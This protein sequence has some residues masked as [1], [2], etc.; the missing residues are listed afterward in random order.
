MIRALAHAA[1]TV[2]AAT[3]AAAVQG[4][5]ILFD[6]VARVEEARSS[7]QLANLRLDLLAADRGV[8][9]LHC[10]SF[11]VADLGACERLLGR[12]NLPLERQSPAAAD[13]G[14]LIADRGAT[15]GVHLLFCSAPKATPPEAAAARGEASLAVTGLD[16]LV[17]RTPDPER[18]IALYAGR[19]GLSLRL[20]RSYPEWGA[21]LTFFRCGDLTIELAHD[22]KRGIGD[23]EDRLWGLSWR[24]AD[25]VG[26]QRRLAAAGVEVSQVRAGRRAGT[27]VCTVRSHS[28]G[29]PTLLIG[30]DRGP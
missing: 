1:I 19:L 28:A 29:V 15:H 6:R 22:L 30:P 26:A 4:Y 8:A 7:F 21:R 24:V 20:D 13:G 17:I 2:P 18:A 10:L 25:V 16:H 27:R 12:R 5:E 3:L 9:G 23:G 11:A 14:P